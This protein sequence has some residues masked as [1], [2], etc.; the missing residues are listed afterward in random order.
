MKLNKNIYI[1]IAVVLVI[2]A[3]YFGVRENDKNNNI[4]ENDTTINLSPT[5]DQLE[6]PTPTPKITSKSLIN[7]AKPTPDLIISEAEDYLSLA[8]SFDKENRLLILD[9]DCLSIFPSQVVYANNTKVMLDNTLS[10]KPRILKIGGREYS[11]EAGKWIFA[12]LSSEK[13]P[14][15]LTMYCGAMELG[16]IELK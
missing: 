11:L 5:M 4:T 15:N 13:L 3:V 14:I 12:T 2:I 10:A 16:Q 6:F 7:T 1:L 8:K 9:K